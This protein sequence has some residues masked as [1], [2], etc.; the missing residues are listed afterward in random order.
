MTETHHRS[1]TPRRL[2]QHVVLAGSLLA[3]PMLG[4]CQQAKPAAPPP[5]SVKPPNEPSPASSATTAEAPATAT[6]TATPT[7]PSAA[8]SSAAETAKR[9][10]KNAA[11]EPDASHEPGCVTFRWTTYAPSWKREPLD[12][13]ASTRTLVREG[14]TQRFD[15][16]GRVRDFGEAGDVMEYDRAGH[17]TFRGRK[18]V[19]ANIAYRYRNT[20]DGKHRL[21]AIDVSMRSAGKWGPYEPYRRYTYDPDGRITHMQIEIHL[22]EGLT[23]TTASYDDAGRL[24]Q[25]VWGGP[26]L[27]GA[28]QV[29]AF[30]YDL[31]GRLSG[32]DRDG[33]ILKGGQPTDGKPDWQQTI[34]YAPEGHVTR[35]EAV[36]TTPA[37]GT[38]RDITLFSPG[39]LEVGR[40]WPNIYVLPY[41]PLPEPQ[42]PHWVR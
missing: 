24:K 7:P 16:H 25:L 13:T 18:D 33:M 42:Q 35:V 41:V 26:S 22:R 3:V 14:F 28:R 4:G 39:C 15:E 11:S 17:P 31:Q 20:Y 29:D 5:Q 12:W 38:E 34:A 6:P 1:W 2:V 36:A 9:T 23:D 8:P 21:T 40:L 10:D 19:P 27:I 32:Y 30:R 37:G